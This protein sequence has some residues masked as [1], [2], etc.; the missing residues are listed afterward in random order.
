MKWFSISQ[1]PRSL[2]SEH[3]EEAINIDDGVEGTLETEDEDC[4]YQYFQSF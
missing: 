3:D 2:E 1:L 4:D